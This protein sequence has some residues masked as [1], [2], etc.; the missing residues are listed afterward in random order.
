MLAGLDIPRVAYY[1]TASTAVSPLGD[2]NP[3]GCL[4][5]I[6][7][8][9]N[10]TLKVVVQGFGFNRHYTVYG[11]SGSR[12]LVRSSAPLNRVMNLTAAQVQAGYT[13]VLRDAHHLNVANQTA[14]GEFT[15]PPTDAIPGDKFFVRRGSGAFN[16]VVKHGRN[17]STIATLTAGQ[18]GEFIMS[19]TGFWYLW[20]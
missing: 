18:A 5:E 12:Q 16:L 9:E 14:V 10:P 13:A 1:S 15:L 6:V 19:D 4:V 7:S 2:A 8:A 17:G 20:R 3:G 11:S